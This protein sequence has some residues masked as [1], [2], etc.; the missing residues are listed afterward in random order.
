[1]TFDSAEAKLAIE[2]N[3]FIFIGGHKCPVLGGGPSGE[4]VLVFHFPYDEDVE[5]LKDAMKRFGTVV[6]VRYQ[7][8]PSVDVHTGTRLVRM[9]RNGPIPRFLDVGGYLCKVWYR[10]QPIVYDI[11]GGGV[12][13]R[14]TVPLR[15]SAA[16]ATKRGTMLGIVQVLEMTIG[17]MWWMLQLICLVLLVGMVWILN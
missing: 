7:S 11:C 3:E 8:Y 16:Y 10:G 1:M 15:E 2:K 13:F 14:T 5:I 17:G 4:N 9:I 12:M 6:G